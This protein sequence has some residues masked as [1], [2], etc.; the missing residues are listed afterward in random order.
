[1]KTQV[2]LENSRFTEGSLT[3]FLLLPC[4]FRPMTLTFEVSLD[5]V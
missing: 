1:M 3:F 2:E 5:N 4:E